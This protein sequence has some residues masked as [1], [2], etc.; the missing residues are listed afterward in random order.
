MKNKIM[1]EEIEEN[2]EEQEIDL[3]NAPDIEEADPDWIKNEDEKLPSQKGDYKISLFLS[4]DGKH[5]VH[6]EVNDPKSRHEAIK[7]G[8]ELY[9][10]ILSRYGTKQAQAVKEYG[11]GRKEADPAACRHVHIGLFQAKK[12]GPNQ[13]KWF[14]SCRDCKKFLGFQS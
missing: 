3:E 14:K 4:T 11:N 9:D 12:E 5:T 2:F 13:G 10:Y 8:T 6:V 1:E 7:K